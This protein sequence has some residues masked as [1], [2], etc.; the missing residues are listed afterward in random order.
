M[1]KNKHDENNNIVGD[2]LRACICSILEISDE[3]VPNFV[4]DDDY[5]EI[6][7]KFL[8]ERNIWLYSSQEEP[9]NVDYYMAW[10]ISPRGL[11]HSVVYSQ[12]KLVHDPHPEGGGVIPDT[13]AWIKELQ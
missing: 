5:P 3:G 12:S 9:Q 1:Q 13:Y 4:E 2:C 8:L 7:S 10:G 6:L 11:Q